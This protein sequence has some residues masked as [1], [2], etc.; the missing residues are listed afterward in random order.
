MIWEI[1]KQDFDGK[2]DQI[3][4]PQSRSTPHQMAVSAGI[5]S[6]PIGF[7]VIGGSCPHLCQ[8]FN[9]PIDLHSLTRKFLWEPQ[10]A[11]N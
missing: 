3:L 11:I 9:P 1:P 7:L 10:C 6:I 4:V 8:S 5:L 2:G